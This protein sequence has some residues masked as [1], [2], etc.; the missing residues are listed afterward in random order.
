MGE[1]EQNAP[2]EAGSGRGDGGR[3]WVAIAANPYSGHGP[4]QKRVAELAAVLEQHGLEP[5]IIWDRDERAELLRRPDLAATCRCV[6]AAGGDGTVADVIN[7]MAAALPLATLPSGNENLFARQFGFTRNAKELARAIAAGNTRRIDL[8]RV[9]GRLFSLML[10]VG[11]DAAVVHRVVA[12]RS[13]GERL[14]RVNRVSYAKPIVSVLRSYGYG[15]VELEADGVR[16]S[17][18]H[19]FVFNLP[20]YG[21]RLPFAPDA[22]GDDGL[23]DWLV[24]ERPGFVS[25]L[26]YFLSLVRTKHLARPDVHHGQARR[27]RITAPEP[28]PVQMDGEAGGMTPVAVEVVRESLQ[29]I[30]R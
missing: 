30:A 1:S 13:N 19:A 23:L 26:S 2:I 28:M 8:A 14:R 10:S 12:W 16:V 5:K 22:R 24:F 15:R 17:G 29:V 6:V 3:T 11:F 9:G 21:F 7:E 27:V 20:Q 18:T 4:T 25:M